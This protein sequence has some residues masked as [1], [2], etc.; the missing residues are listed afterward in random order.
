MKSPIFRT[1]LGLIAALAITLAILMCLGLFSYQALNAAREATRLERHTYLVIDGF[2]KLLSSLQDAET[3]QRGFIIT[4]DRKYLAPFH[5]GS[6]MTQKRLANLRSLTRDNPNQQKR[7]DSI[8]ALV[9]TKLSELAETT[10]LRAAKGFSSARDR[11]MTNLGKNTMDAIRESVAQAGLEEERLLSIRLA[12]EERYSG[13]AF[14]MVLLGNLVGAIFILA[15]YLFLWCEFVRRIKSENELTAN[16]D[17]LDLQNKELQRAI[18]EREEV[19]AQLGKYSDLYDYAPVGYL[20]LD[21]NGVIRTVNITGSD[22]LGGKHSLNGLR[23]E[24]LVADTERP[25]FESFLAKVFTSRTK[26]TCELALLDGNSQ[27]FVQVEAVAATKGQECRIV[28]V[29]VTKR[30]RVEEALH[31]S[32]ERYRTLAMASTDV[33][34]RMSPDWSEMLQL[35]GRDFIADTESPN[36]NWLQE[37]IYQDDQPH[38]MTVISEAIRTKK[39]FELEH[40]VLRVDGT[41]GWTFSRAVPQLDANGEIVEWFGS[42]S[43]VTER[44]RAEDELRLS[45]DRFRTMANAMPQLAWMAHAD[46]FIYWYNQRWYEYTGTTPDQVEGWGWQSV[47]DPQMLPTVLEQWRASIAT[48][49]PFEMIFPLKRADGVFGLFLTRMVPFRDAQGIIIQW[50]GTNTDITESEERFQA[51]FNQAAVGIGHLKLDGRWLRINQKFCD[52][53]GYSEKEL[54]VLTLKDIT[55]PDDQER[56]IRLFQPLIDGKLGDYSLEKR[57]IRKDGSTVW[58]NHT[59]TMVLDS[60]GNPSF[61]V[62][63]IE[64]ITKRKQSELESQDARKYAENIVET[65]TEPLVVLSSEL[66]ILTANHSFYHTFKVTPEETIGNFIYDLGNRQWDIPRL[67]VLFEEILPHDTVINSY[68][69]EHDFLDIGR[70]VIVLSARQIFRENIGSHIILLAMADITDQKRAGEEIMRL[71]SDLASR[72]DE[73]ESANTELEAFNYTVAHDLRQPLNLLGLCNQGIEMLHCCD[74]FQGECADYIQTIHKTTLKMD[75]IIETLLNFARVGQVEPRREVVDLSMLAHEVAKSLELTEPERQCD[76]QIV[77]GIV[78]YADASLLQVV[79]DNLLGN[80]WKYSSM[81][82]KAVIEL[83]VKDI[84]GVPSYFV[85]DNGTGFDMTYAGRLFTPFHRLPETEKLKGFGIG[86][87]T[88]DRIIRRH[89]GKVWAEG[90]PDKGATFYFTLPAD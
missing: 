54:R 19:E 29:D 42:A 76:F 32:E 77:D 13:R 82:E 11:V 37:Y 22:L 15:L 73:L 90:E 69:V 45:E 85:Q 26:E 75:H 31:E 48:G 84:D 86:L 71:N 44:K 43:D 58:V 62:S 30:K 33:V 46:G 5:D 83:G 63:V 9:R 40:R 47:Q 17:Q 16:R 2:D 70:K 10:N 65:V 7:L 87:A 49:E 36:P 4:G 20:N 35:Y 3:G 38:V 50:F 59:V 21:Q 25:A 66:K 78:A 28:L 52:I 41:L 79:L 80:A 1:R 60:S 39:I 64:D 27:L 34:Y 89:G 61:I 8:E 74:Q 18:D 67:R 24:D 72:A 12:L 51:T 88:V 6:K 57:L 23:L 68:E 14:K 81:R 55:H 53:V 56:S